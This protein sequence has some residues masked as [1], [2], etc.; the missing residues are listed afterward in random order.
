MPLEV[1]LADDHVLFRQALKVLLEREGFSV[2]AEACDGHE[3]VR[4]AAT[5]QPDIAVLDIAMPALNGL[6]AARQIAKVSS[7]TKT[8]ALTMYVED[9][10][11][12]G[13]LRAGMRGYVIK[14][15]AA[16]DLVAA[17]R[18]VNQGQI[19][20]SP[21]VSGAIVDGFLNRTSPAEDPLTGRER[22]VVQLVAEGKTS[23]EIAD[24]LELGVKSVESYRT[25][26]MQKLEIHNTA[27][28]VRYA[29]RQGLV[30]P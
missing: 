28:L 8:I 7:R 19:Y 9:H 18:T 17:I 24:I 27:G 25:R 22:Q 10:Y 29:I 15:Q 3:A 14:T 23:K 4:L 12:I 26:I 20:L 5:L 13:A 1:L 16:L 11:V 30:Q 2:P 6:D 21:G